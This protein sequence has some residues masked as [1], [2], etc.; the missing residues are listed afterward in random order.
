VG[1]AA[2]V[3]DRLGIPLMGHRATIERLRD[4]VP[5]DRAME[6]GERI[7]LEGEKP[8]TLRA[9]HTPG[10]APGHLCFFEE[11][12]RACIV[13][14]M[15]ASVGT[16]LIEPDDGDMGL[17]LESLSHLRGLGAR[18]LLPAHGG[19]I[20]DPDPVLAHYIAHRLERENRVLHALRAQGGPASARDLVPA[21]YA[22]APMSVWPLAARSVEA[23]LLKLVREGRARETGRGYVA[24]A[25]S[26]KGA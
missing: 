2:A 4:D 22:D 16:I 17:Y 23:H 14:D 11:T 13:G 19:P 6:D 26:P 8:M 10:H 21:A 20:Q 7:E 24:E 9:E 1:G 12:T 5:F 15:V 18:V 25:P 3:R